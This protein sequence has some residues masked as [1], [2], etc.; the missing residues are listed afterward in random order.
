MYVERL[1]E[2]QINEFARM[3]KTEAQKVT[4]SEWEMIISRPFNERVI[5]AIYC[6]NPVWD[7]C[8]H[9][10][11]FHVEIAKSLLVRHSVIKEIYAKFMY[12]IFGKE[13]RREYIAEKDKIFNN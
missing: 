10:Y 11:D 3:L 8:V 2:E 5:I 7:I 9:M 13:Y 1:T 12:G 6:T 4:N